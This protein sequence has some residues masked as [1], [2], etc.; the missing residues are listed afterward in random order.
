MKS[1]SSVGSAL[2]ELDR[3]RIPGA[4]GAEFGVIPKPGDFLTGVLTLL[5]FLGV[6]ALRGVAGTGDGSSSG[7]GDG[8]VLVW[9]SRVSFTRLLFRSG[10]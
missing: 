6:E 7:F 9:S 5:P 4:A 8:I 2:F 10:D 1:V 3:G